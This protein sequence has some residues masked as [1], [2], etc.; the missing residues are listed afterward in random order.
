MD[1]QKDLVFNPAL[2]H[3]EW[4]LYAIQVSASFPP[5]ASNTYPRIGLKTRHRRVQISVEYID[6]LG[7]YEISI[8]QTTIAIVPKIDAVSLIE[9]LIHKIDSA[10]LFELLM[11][12][13]TGYHNLLKAVSVAGSLSMSPLSKLP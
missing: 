3:I 7:K 6:T 5:S 8:F 4:C 2:K 12:R 11:D 10:H 13:I 9:Q 1:I